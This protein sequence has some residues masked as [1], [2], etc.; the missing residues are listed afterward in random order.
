MKHIYKLSLSK[1]EID[2][3]IGYYSSRNKAF[4][5]AENMI[6]RSG[7]RV[8]VKRKRPGTSEVIGHRGSYY[9]VEKIW[10]E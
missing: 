5:V 8:L 4:E 6:E 2:I 3:S 9:V 7:Q 10:V 1:E